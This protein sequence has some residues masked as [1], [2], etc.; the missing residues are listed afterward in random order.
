MAKEHKEAEE[1]R[2]QQDKKDKERWKT[3]THPG[4]MS[5]EEIIE[6]FQPLTILSLEKDDQDKKLSQKYE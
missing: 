2:D 4:S 5:I 1:N 3:T 6:T